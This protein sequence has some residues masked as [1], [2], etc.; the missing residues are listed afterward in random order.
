MWHD[1]ARMTR[2]HK[3]AVVS[4]FFFAY[5]LL[6][7]RE[8]PW[9]DAR[10]LHQVAEALVG[11]GA[12]NVQM[13][14]PLAR[15]GK[16]YA[17]HPLLVSAVHVPGVLLH[18]AAAR[19]W[20]SADQPARAMGSHIGSS[21]L[22]ALVCLMFM[23]ICMQLGVSF[24]AASLSALILGF[25]TMIAVYARSPW[26][27]ITQTAAFVG[28]YLWLLRVAEVPSRRTALWF[29]VWT[30]LLVNSKLIFALALPGAIVYA[31]QKILRAHGR[32]VL[33]RTTLMVALGALPGL[34][35]VLGYNFART[36]SLLGTGYNNLS[37]GEAFA[38][39]IRVGL[40]GLFFS[41]G[42]SV[43]L[44][45]PPLIVAL[46]ALPYALRTRSRDWLV[47][48]IATAA[49][50][51][52]VY[53]R[54]SFWAGDWC[55]GPRYI[56]FL[57]PIALLPA[58]FLFDDLLDA[59]HRWTPPAWAGLLVLGFWIQVLGAAF[60]WDHFIRIAQEART[61]W[62]G[63][64]NRT[65]AFPPDRGGACDPCFE[66]L[67][68]LNWLPAF[69]PLEG[70]AWLFRHVRAGDSW[71]V[72]EAD[73]P[74][75]RYTNL[76]LNI[77]RSYGAVRIDWWLLDFKGPLRPGGIVLLLLMSLGTAVSAGF[78]VRRITVRP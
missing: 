56:L 27:E 5:L 7:S 52:V 57:V 66:D 33:W 64:V 11:R 55:W 61:Q 45:N 37:G 2:R 54:Y 23:Q 48:L 42:K 26:S 39:K 21:L 4:T 78:W 13:N 31:G 14:T 49:P 77:A 70:H 25:A 15:D 41:P 75:R 62:L 29:G 20:P 44:Y 8:Q 12:V 28:F 34:L 32:E 6:G 73:A 58:V 1:D 63:P 69:S 36:H 43:F 59:Q 40:W 51:V 76:K 47:A 65:G 18:K 35:L 67:H 9:N 50:V 19:L 10:Q 53:S 22:G 17:A 60:Y 71:Q 16:H 46:L 30:A 68:G 3:L 72:A 24:R 74:W 38:E